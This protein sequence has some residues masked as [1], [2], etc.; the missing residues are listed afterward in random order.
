MNS[1]INR[2]NRARTPKTIPTIAAVLLL[3]PLSGSVSF[4][5]KLLSVVAIEIHSPSF[6]TYWSS[7][8]VGQSF[9]GSMD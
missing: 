5:S 2:A 1:P 6:T 3:L 8:G 9:T 7:L 4:K